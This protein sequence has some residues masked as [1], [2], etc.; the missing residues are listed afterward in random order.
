M[1]TVGAIA[2]SAGLDRATVYYYFPDKFAIFRAA[3][4]EGLEEVFI[5][6]DSCTVGEESSANRLQRAIR[7]AMDVFERHYPYL[8]IYFREGSV[9]EV[10]DKTSV[11]KRCIP[12]FAMK[13]AAWDHPRRHRQW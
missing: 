3:I 9:S 4:H 1:P 13:D 8:Y 5:A 6:L 2:K 12:D 7:I 10:I 11:P